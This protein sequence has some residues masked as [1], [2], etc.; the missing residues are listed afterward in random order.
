MTTIS[1]NLKTGNV[2]N[3]G[4]A[5]ISGLHGALEIRGKIHG[6]EVTPIKDGSFDVLRNGI[7]TVTYKMI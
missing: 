5:D 2:T 1:T 6:W 7:S 4:N 3:H